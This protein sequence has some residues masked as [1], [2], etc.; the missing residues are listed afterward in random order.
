MTP[1]ELKHFAQLLLDNDSG[2]PAYAE[3]DVELCAE[4]RRL[5]GGAELTLEEAGQVR[6]LWQD[7][8]ATTQAAGDS[9]E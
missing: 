5:T 7:L 6:A 3:D 8:Q 1:V 9:S 2:E 4:V